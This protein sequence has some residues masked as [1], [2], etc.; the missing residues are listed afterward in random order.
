MAFQTA[1]SFGLYEGNLRRLIHLLKYD[2]MTPLAR[3]LAQRLA[4]VV[5]RLGPLELIVPVPLHRW[6]RW[7]RGFNQSALLAKELS[8]VAA[9]PFD[10]R[11]LRRGRATKSQAGLSDEERRV[12]VKGAF[13]V[14]AA[15]AVRGRRVLVV[16]D[17]ITT[18]ATLSACAD[19]L[20]AAGA[21][22]V[23]AL[24]LARVER[25]GNI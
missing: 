22:S 12:N 24:T 3:P 6:R 10:A 14:R 5:P 18:G 13:Q 19:A 16:D 21:R 2:K 7:G 9:L 20:N 1:R 4:V 15:A 25:G 8:R 23:A 17:V 11:L